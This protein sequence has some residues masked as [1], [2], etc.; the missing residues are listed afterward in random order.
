MV[1]GFAVAAV[2]RIGAGADIDVVVENGTVGFDGFAGVPGGLVGAPRFS[3]EK[4]TNVFA[5]FGRFGEPALAARFP[6]T[7]AAGR[8]ALPAA[9]VGGAAPGVGGVAARFA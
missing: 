2:T 1:A 4:S 6:G 5:P 9:G 3:P 8:G 7:P